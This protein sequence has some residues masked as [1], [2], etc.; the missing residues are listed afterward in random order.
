MIKYLEGILKNITSEQIALISV[1]VTILLYLLGKHNELKFKKHELKKEKYMQF[2]DLLKDAY[3]KG[4]EIFSK[5]A[6][7]TKF[8][9]FGSTVFIYGSKK[10]IR[11]IAFLE[12][13]AV[14]L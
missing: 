13:L 8:F 14:I 11:N 1:I 4:G 6:Y 3:L 10:C 7:K 12:K 9:D 2:L 5:E